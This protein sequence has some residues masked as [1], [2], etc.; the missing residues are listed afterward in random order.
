VPREYIRKTNRPYVNHKQMPATYHPG[1]LKALDQR[2]VFA[3]GLRQRYDSLAE[4]LGGAANLS[5]IKASLLERFVYLE[6]MLARLE[7]EIGLTKD[8]NTA[9][10]TTS[11][12]IQGLNALSGLAS[13]LGLDKH[14]RKVDLKTYLFNGTREGDE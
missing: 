13:K 6:V 10:K 5:G 14:V 11:R 7:A 1:F 12:W 4:D 2:T 8:A 3:R 9:E